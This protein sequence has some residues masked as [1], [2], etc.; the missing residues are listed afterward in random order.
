M[1]ADRDQRS[2][3]ARWARAKRSAS[4]P[5]TWTR[6]R[7]VPA[8]SVMAIRDSRPARW[9]IIAGV[10]AILFGYAVPPIQAASAVGASGGGL[11]GLDAPSLAFP[12]FEEPPADD[13]S[14]GHGATGSDDGEAPAAA[15]DAG[16][17]S[18][19]GG[20]ATARDAAT[21][22][23]EIFENTYGVG[24]HPKGPARDRFAGVAAVEDIRGALPVVASAGNAGHAQ[25]PDPHDEGYVGTSRASRPD[26]DDPLPSAPADRRRRD[27]A[28]RRGAGRRSSGIG[29]RRAAIASCRRQRRAH[30]AAAG[31]RR[32][33]SA[34]EDR[35]AQRRLAR[36]TRRCCRRDG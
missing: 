5:A 11:P 17:T 26:A 19:P 3:A 33:R 2:S 14:D 4:P 30:A 6:A 31:D 27:D 15:P 29:P 23:P 35:A 36:T 7:S 9:L 16:G 13:P 12:T 20:S 21:P 32:G 18:G 25:G 28:C 22:Q 1:M 10:V 24:T 8:P 34:G